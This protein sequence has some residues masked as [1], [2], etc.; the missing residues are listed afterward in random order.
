MFFSLVIKLS[1]SNSYS[2]MKKIFAEDN[3]T[4]GTVNVTKPFCHNVNLNEEEMLIYRYTLV[5]V[6]YIIPVCVISFVYIQVN[7]ME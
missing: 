4:N 2:H 1:S 7:L 5:I 3:S 6:Q